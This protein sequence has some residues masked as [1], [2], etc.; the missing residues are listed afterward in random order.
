MVL[1]MNGW[2][3]VAATT[4]THL[5]SGLL[6]LKE[7]VAQ[8]LSFAVLPAKANREKFLTLLF[9]S[10]LCHSTLSMWPAMDNGKHA[11]N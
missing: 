2:I 10:R 11:D 1:M 3:V 8:L 7:D 9:V 5:G 6:F 4:P